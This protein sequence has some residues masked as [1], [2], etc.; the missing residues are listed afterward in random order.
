MS[1]S[2]DVTGLPAE[3]IV[4]GPSPL[5]ELASALHV[6]AEPG[7]HPGLHG[8]A[9]ATAA[10]LKPELADRLHQADFLWRSARADF[11]IPARP[12]ATLGEE[13]DDLDELDDES[14]VGAALEICGGNQERCGTSPLVDARVRARTRELAMARG[15]RQ[16]EFADRLLADPGRVRAWIRALLEDC[17]RAFFHDVWQRTRGQLAADA[18]HKT[19]LLH[20]RGLADA[21]HAVSSALSLDDGAEGGDA[22]TGGGTPRGTNGTS[23]KGGKG[24][25][26]GTGGAAGGSVRRRIVVDKL[27]EG[28]TT[29]LETG[30]RGGPGVTFI[31]S[32]LGWPHLYALHAPNWRP[33]VLYPAQAAELPQPAALDL[34]R[35]RLEA[36]S[37][38]QRL[39]LCRNLARA[40]YTTGEL[41]DATGMSAPEVSRHLAV[42]R[43]AGLLIA[44]RR[45][46]YVQNRLDLTAAAR[47]G[48]DFL[49]VVLR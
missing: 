3:R 35:R 27:S 18:R 33:A 43:K 20:R 21:L 40:P 31:P 22:G 1:I 5:A 45:G 19:E 44:R 4:F 24:S 13:L 36:V 48:G 7:H 2:I 26:N 46:R 41:A 25:T 9:T 38:P 28:R 17:D 32:A 15:P 14:F 6:L 11:L 23:G 34:V 16:A 47:L 8:W 29:A 39:L 49:E 42:M 30:V 10:G 12:R 37:H